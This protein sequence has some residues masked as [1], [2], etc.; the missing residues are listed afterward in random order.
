MVWVYYLNQVSDEW[1]ISVFRKISGSE[2]GICCPENR[3]RETYLSTTIGNMK[4]QYMKN[5]HS[6]YFLPLSNS[7]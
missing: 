5:E 7:T 2:Q 1:H 4:N 6:I 3:N